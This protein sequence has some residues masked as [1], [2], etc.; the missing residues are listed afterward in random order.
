[1]A[2]VTPG[3]DRAA[4]LAEEARSMLAEARSLLADLAPII[5]GARQLGYYDCLADQADQLA[6]ARA[7]RERSRFQVITGGAA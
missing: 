3:P 4:D 1:M 2:T 7:R 6:A 5:R